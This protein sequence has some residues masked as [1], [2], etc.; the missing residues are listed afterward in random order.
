MFSQAILHMDLDAFFVSVEI[1]KDSRLRGKPVIIG[2]HSGRS[3]VAS[4]S[5]EARKFG[6]HSA[7]PIKLALRLCPQAIIRRGDMDTYASYSRLITSIIES[8]APCFEKASIDEFYLDLTGMDRHF[9]VWKWAMELRNKVTDESGLPISIGLAVN[10]LVSKVGVNVDKPR[11]ERM[12][13]PGTERAFFN[14]L[15]IR[16][17]PSVGRKTYRKLSFMGVKKIKALAEIPPAFLEQ[18]FGKPGLSLWKK[19][20]A[21]DDSKVVPYSERKS[22][23]HEHTFEIDTI[24][25]GLLRRYLLKMITQLGYELRQKHKLASIVTVK[26][27]YTDFNTHTK[28][29][30]I[31][32]TASDKTLLK[33]VYELFEKL[34]ERRQLVRLVGVKV[35]GLVGGHYQVNLFEDTLRDISLLTTLDRIKQ[36]FGTHAIMSASVLD[37]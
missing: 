28:Q 33:V 10:K 8:E 12:V 7:M 23:S 31:P 27:R 4:C 13:A 3:V 15:S 5:Y 36:R 35:S 1:L 17:L 29:R 16:Q 18:E 9:G 19:A 14:P 21:I 22:I 32:Y 24:D 37:H 2:G 25:V 30:R 20:N 6:V 34:F 26:I 11:A